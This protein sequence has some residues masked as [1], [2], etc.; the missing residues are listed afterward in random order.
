[1]KY[2][3]AYGQR[4]KGCTKIIFYAD[5]TKDCFI[6]HMLFSTVNIKHSLIK[7]QG[8]VIVA[9]EDEVWVQARR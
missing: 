8:I 3:F 4:L 7:G 5:G 2:I 1:M 6:F 9:A